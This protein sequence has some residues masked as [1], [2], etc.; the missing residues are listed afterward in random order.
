MI[1][2]GSVFS[3]SELCAPAA[4][5]NRRQRR[6]QRKSFC[7]MH[8]G[9]GSAA[10]SHLGVRRATYCFRIKEG[11][12]KAQ[13]TTETIN[14]IILLFLS[15]GRSGQPVAA[16]QHARRFRLRRPGDRVGDSRQKVETIV[17]HR[18]LAV[19]I[20]TRPPNEDRRGQR[21]AA[22]LPYKLA[23]LQVHGR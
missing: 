3:C 20:Q 9:C 21:R 4:K 11:T 14:Y 16:A 17:S 6:K 12:E 5:V 8:V 1:S 2:V 22:R 7:M 23:G 18:R 13:R 15:S 10:P 19:D